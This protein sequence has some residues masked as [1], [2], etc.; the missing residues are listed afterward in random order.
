M[1][2]TGYT[3]AAITAGQ[4][5][6]AEASG[7]RKSTTGE[8]NNPDAFILTDGSGNDRYPPKAG[9][10]AVGQP[11]TAAE[12][13][14]LLGQAFSIM[15]QTRAQIRQPLNSRAQVTISVVDT[16]GAVLGVV[17]SPDAPVFGIDVSLQKA[18]TASFFSGPFAAADLMSDPDMA[19]V[20]MPPPPQIGGY[21]GLVRS[22][23]ALPTALT[24]ATAFSARSIGN[25][26][27][28]Q[29]PDGQVGGPNGPLAPPISQFNPFD[30]G[31]QSDFILTTLG[32][33]P[34]C[35]HISGAG[36]MRLANGAQIFP[37]G[38]SDLSRLDPGR[39][40]R[41]I[42]RRRQPGRHDRL[43]RPRRGGHP[44]QHDPET[45]RRRCAPTSSRSIRA[46]GSTGC[47]TSSAPWR[48]SSIHRCR[49]PVR[50]NRR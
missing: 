48:R 25:L 6:G 37:G 2:V 16:N 46:A 28:P 41:H 43:P 7:I 22:F 21:V 11:L 1:A 29:F 19:T 49:T 47:S 14:T 34:P 23:L 36:S 24:G 13:T 3:A 32:G 39:R 42:R 31:F 40:D 30:T 35:G 12:V 20:P 10:D 5:Y 8:F 45:R 38:V 15:S 4:T 26:E 50:G 27:R 18:R 44:D 17:R 9:T 33:P